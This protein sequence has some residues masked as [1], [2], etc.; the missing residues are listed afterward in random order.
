M[1]CGRFVLRKF[2]SEVSQLDQK[3]LWALLDEDQCGSATKLQFGQEA[4]AL[5]ACEQ[6]F[7]SHCRP[8]PYIFSVGGPCTTV[9]KGL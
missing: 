3:L 5:A 2:L 8:Y 9:Y 4:A 7:F 1:L 6:L